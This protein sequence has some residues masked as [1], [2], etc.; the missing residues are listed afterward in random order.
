[1]LKLLK[2]CNI[3][4]YSSNTSSICIYRYISNTNVNNNRLSDKLRIHLIGIEYNEWIST[5]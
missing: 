2:Y 1:M 3:S 4:K 5:I